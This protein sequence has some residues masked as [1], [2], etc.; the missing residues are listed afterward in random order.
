LAITHFPGSATTRSSRRSKGSVPLRLPEEKKRYYANIT[1]FDAGVGELLTYLEREGLREQTLIVYVSDNGWQVSS[2]VR[3][4]YGGPKGKNTLYEVGFRT[5]VI[6]SWPGHIPADRASDALVSAVDVFATLLDYAGAALP[7]DR[8][9]RSLRP[10]LEGR[11]AGVRDVIIGAMDEVRASVAAG[12]PPPTATATR[13]RGA[14]FSATGAGTTSGTRRATTSCTIWKRIPTRTTTSLCGTRRGSR[15]SADACR[16]GMP[17]RGGDSLRPRRRRGGS[18]R[19]D[20]FQWRWNLGRVG[21]DLKVLWE[22]SARIDTRDLDL[23]LGETRV[24][25][26][27]FLEEGILVL[28][29]VFVPLE[30]EIRV[31]PFVKENAGLFVGKSVLEIGTGSGVISVY[32]ARLGAKRVVSTDISEVALTTAA[33]NAKRLGVASVVETR[34]VP[35]EDISA[36]SVIASDETFDIIISNPP[37]SLDLDARENS[38]MTDRGDLGFS[39]VRGLDSHLEPGGV[40]MLLY[41]SLF[42]HHVMVKFA[43]SQGFEVRN[44][45]PKKMTPLEAETLFN[46]YLSRLLDLEPNESSDFRFDWR[47]DDGLKTIRV[48]AD[49]SKPAVPLLPGNSDSRFPGMIVIQKRQVGDHMKGG[50][51]HPDPSFVDGV[52]RPD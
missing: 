13:G 45:I 19:R 20:R 32:A 38:A 28:P 36:Y 48:V 46:F 33:R 17:R 43:R 30:A 11:T 40:A 24:F 14:A 35:Q 6:F 52:N 22:I 34:L 26:S 39:I 18:T 5:P 12:Q 8:S 15:S 1:R 42:Y 7:A 4:Q 16:S 44:H 27:R 41:G 29:G 23:D 31:L 49:K 9:G 21:F 50:G 51:S 47:T 3:S 25:P 10:V 2:E 37:Y